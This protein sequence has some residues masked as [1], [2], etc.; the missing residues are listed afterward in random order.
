VSGG[1][2][3]GDRDRVRE[4]ILRLGGTLLFR[5]VAMRPGRPT[6]FALI[7]GKPI[8]A[9]PGNPVSAMVSFEL[10]ARPA[11]LAMGGRPRLFRPVVPAI[12]LEEIRN[13]RP[14]RLFLRGRLENRNGK[15]FVSIAGSQS[16][17][18]L[19]SMVEAD[20]LV[21]AEPGVE[22]SPGEEAPVLLLSEHLRAEKEGSYREMTTLAEP[23]FRRS[24][25]TTSPS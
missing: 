13:E 20:G 7:G 10:L 9:L 2:S 4:A 1:I 14:E 8:F 25:K 5:R 11:L 18:R 19:A 24:L 3:V 17:A 22:L 21:V 16:S 15:A 6:A 23:S 12:L